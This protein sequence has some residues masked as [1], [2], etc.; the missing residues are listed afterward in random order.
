MSAKE[1]TAEWWRQNDFGYSEILWGEMVKLHHQGNFAAIWARL[2]QEHRDDYEDG[3]DVLDK[4][5]EALDFCN[6]GRYG[7]TREE[8]EK[9]WGLRH[10]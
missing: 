9:L 2:F 4:I 8:V 3:G 5:L 10:E 6:F 1:T 7:R